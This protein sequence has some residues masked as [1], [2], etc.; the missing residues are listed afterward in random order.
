MIL[1]KVYIILCG[2]LKKEINDLIKKINRYIY[3][4]L[5]DPGLHRSKELV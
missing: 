5:I 3:F 1:K 4:D 2:S